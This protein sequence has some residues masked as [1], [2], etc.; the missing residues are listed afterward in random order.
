MRQIATLPDEP[1]A[2]RFADYL[3]TVEIRTQLIDETGGVGV[4]ICDEDKVERA[5]QELVE[6]NRSPG[7]PRYTQAAPLAQAKRRQEAQ[8]ER[9]YTRRQRQ[10]ERGMASGLAG[11]RPLTIALVA[12]S[13]L[14]ALATNFGRPGSPLVQQLSI[15]TYFEPIPLAPGADPEEV[16][17]FRVPPNDLAQVRAG[18]VWRLVTPI[19]LHFTFFHLLFNTYMLYG[20]GGRIEAVRGFWRYGLLVL[21]L[22]VGSNLAEY[23]LDWS[24]KTGG[25]IVVVQSASFGGMSGVLYG[26]F[27]YAWMKSRY[28]PEGGLYVPSDMVVMML[29]WFVLCLAGVIGPIA[30]VAHGAGLA[31]GMAIGYVPRLFPPREG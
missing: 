28:D 9:D 3:L 24:L 2:R 10:F 15:A 27:G 14:V 23:Y 5:R 11:E 4:W 21:V 20:L 17:G 19:F 29:G 22:A 8:L 31:L 25:Q 13:V 30:N 12:I 7:D 6:F 18:Q 26:L 1:T 16:M